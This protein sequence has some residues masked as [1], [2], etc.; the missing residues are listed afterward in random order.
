VDPRIA[1]LLPAGVIAYLL[2]RGWTQT[3]DSNPQWLRFEFPSQNGK[4]PLSQVIP[5]SDN[6]A[7][8]TQSMIYFLTT[9]S[10]IED[11]HPVEILDNI[12]HQQLTSTPRLATTP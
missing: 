4:A 3:H 1:Q 9:L 5:E 6:I 7:D 2:S 8:F 10:E 11:R 12:L